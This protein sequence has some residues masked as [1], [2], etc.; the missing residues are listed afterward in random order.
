MEFLGSCDT[1]L[2]IELIDALWSSSLGQF[3]QMN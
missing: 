1:I 2:S 3:Y